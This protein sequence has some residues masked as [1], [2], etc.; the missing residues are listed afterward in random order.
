[1]IP[2]APRLAR[3]ARLGF[4]LTV[5]LL[6]ACRPFTV[7][8]RDVDPDAARIATLRCEGAFEAALA[9]AR[10]R[11]RRASWFRPGWQRGDWTRERQT[12]DRILAAPPARR[13]DFAAADRALRAADSLSRLERW[14]SADSLAAW[15]QQVRIDALGARHPEVLRAISQRARIA[16][17]SGAYGAAH[18][19]DQQVLTARRQA[20]GETHPET[21]ESE[22]QLGMDLKLVNR[23]LIEAIAI[24]RQSLALRTRLFGPADP[25][26][27]EC[28]VALGNLY[29]RTEH[30][31]D[32]FA[33]FDRA[34]AI[35]RRT[36]GT[37]S[38]EVVTTL[39][40]IGYARSAHDEWAAAITSFEDAVATLEGCTDCTLR[41][42]T[43]AMGGLGVALRHVGRAR[44]A[45]AILEE[46]C[47]LHELMRSNA[48]P[49]VSKAFAYEMTIY[50]ELAA[51]QIENGDGEAAWT[52][53]ER[54]QA[55]ELIEAI[56]ARHPEAGP[57]PPPALKQVQASL[58]PDAALIGWLDF[59][60]TRG[61]E[62]YP[63]WCYAL[64]HEG[65]IHWVRIDRDRGPLRSPRASMDSV[66]TMLRT[67]A[68]WPVRVLDTLTIR[69]AGQ[70]V[71][72]ARIA[73]LEPYLD[74]VRQLIVSSPDVMR[75]VPLQAL[76]DT[77][78]RMLIDRFQITYTPSATYRMWGRAHHQPPLEPSRWTALLLVQPSVV[79][80]LGGADLTH[81]RDEVST[82]AQVI[83]RSTVLTGDAAS[84]ARLQSL[85]DSGALARFDLLHIATHAV[86]DEARPERGA[87]LLAHV[88]GDGTDGR[89]RAAEIESRWQLRARLVGLV[90]CGTQVGRETSTEGIMGLSQALLGTGAE[91]VL[92]STW[93]VDDASTGLL[94]QRFYRDLVGRPGGRPLGPCQALREAQQWLRH[95]RDPDGRAPYAHPAYWAGV[96]LIGE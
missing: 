2:K 71:Y 21:A 94:M 37:G 30:W 40:D 19:L 50:W 62:E 3:F 80:A 45:V 87:L 36:L 56:R 20:F 24:Q 75:G 32:C 43:L 81:A 89:L 47:R 64:R 4:S 26:V 86:S 9:L 59:R 13:S 66:R 84:E 57:I 82:I 83:P 92:T 54:A 15:A 95:Q 51:A 65:P 6:G 70:T 58:A 77:A 38:P 67:S 53:V 18:D 48:E 28:L 14:A 90:G 85:A 52:S 61:P 78:G 1:M 46:T 96:V 11:E 73:P 42:R 35:Q 29:R 31:N 27:A 63:Y 8:S 10:T 49:L 91:R 55:R 34:L 69:R 60:R 16:R 93:R 79:P 74:Q 5:L 12:L 68:A 33:T 17:G 76:C 44:E 72:A 39:A 25:A 22:Y 88:A 23:P 7:G 41:Q